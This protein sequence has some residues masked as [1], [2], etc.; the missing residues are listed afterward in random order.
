MFKKL[1]IICGL[2]EVAEVFAIIAI[3]VVSL[4]K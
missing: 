2:A 3:A 4:F 1:K